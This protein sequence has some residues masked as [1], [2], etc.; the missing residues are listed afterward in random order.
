MSL[1]YSPIRNTLGGATT[2]VGADPPAEG[3]YWHALI[4]ERAAADFLDVSPRTMQSGR[5]TGNGPPFVRLSARAVKYR[6]VDLRA[7]SEKRLV[8]ST[9][10][11]GF[12]P[13]PAAAA[14][15]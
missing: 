5:Q 14:V 11:P 15:A 3:D 4:D 12:Q 9:S 13:E 8:Q 10:D 2:A 6:R 7:H 1:E